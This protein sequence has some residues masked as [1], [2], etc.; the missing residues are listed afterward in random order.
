MNAAIRRLAAAGSA[1]LLLRLAFISIGSLGPWASG[2]EARI[3]RI[4]IV[5]TESPTFGGRTFGA[6][7]AYE[8]LRGRAYG[9][10]DPSDPRNALIVDLARAPRNA[11][12]MVEYSMD[13]Y[14]L[15]PIDLKKGNGKL[16]FE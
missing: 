13:I 7:G 11:R 4:E 16:F 15:K 10:V 2:A 14:I 8:K 1:R 9:E 3:T 6:V 12:G 5:S